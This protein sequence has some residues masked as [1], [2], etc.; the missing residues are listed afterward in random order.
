LFSFNSSM[1]IRSINVTFGHVYS[2]AC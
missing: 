2:L 1:N